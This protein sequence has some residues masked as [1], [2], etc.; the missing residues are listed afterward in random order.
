M[1]LLVG[2]IVLSG[3]DNTSILNSS[4]TLRNSNTLY[5]SPKGT[6]VPAKYGSAPKPSQFRPAAGARPSGPATGAN[7]TLAPFPRNSWPRAY[8]LAYIKSRLKVAPVVIPA[9]NTE[10][11]STFLT[12]I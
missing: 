3:C 4:D 7:A 9:G 1:D 12:P 5:K 11:R 10:T 8:P 6:Y 2:D